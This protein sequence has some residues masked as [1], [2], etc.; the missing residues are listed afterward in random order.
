LIGVKCQLSMN[1]EQ[2]LIL[3]NDNQSGYHCVFLLN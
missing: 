2:F 3:T 1:L